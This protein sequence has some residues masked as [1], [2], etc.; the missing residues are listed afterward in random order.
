MYLLLKKIILQMSKV[1]FIIQIYIFF[2]NY[3]KNIVKK[4]IRLN[5]EN[6]PPKNLEDTA[7]I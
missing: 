1:I 2:K 6:L 7:C 5:F 4:P 3:Y